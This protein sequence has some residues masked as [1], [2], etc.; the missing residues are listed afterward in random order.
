MRAPLADVIVAIMFAS[1]R[2]KVPPEDVAPQ[3]KRFALSAFLLETYR[4]SGVDLSLPKRNSGGHP[5]F[6]RHLVGDGRPIARRVWP[7][8]VDSVEGRGEE[9]A[10]LAR[11]TCERAVDESLRH[12]LNKEGWLD[13]LSRVAVPSL[14]HL[15]ERDPLAIERLVL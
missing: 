2:W 13:R 14:Q 8:L 10:H 3:C 6:A 5:L 4:S 15:D 9:A 12:H 1:C 7:L 11:V